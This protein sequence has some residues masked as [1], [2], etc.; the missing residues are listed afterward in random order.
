MNEETKNNQDTFDKNKN[1]K[2]DRKRT[3][4]CTINKPRLIKKLG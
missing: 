2:H 4:T 3:K 1:K